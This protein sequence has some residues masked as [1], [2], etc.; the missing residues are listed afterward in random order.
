[1]VEQAHDFVVWNPESRGTAHCVAAI[2]RAGKW[3]D[4]MVLSPTP[5]E[6]A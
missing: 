4:D 2:K 6:V 1:M 5:A 3:R